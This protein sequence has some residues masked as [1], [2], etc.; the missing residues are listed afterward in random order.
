[1][2]R[3]LYLKTM[4]AGGAMAFAKAAEMGNP[5]ELHV[6]LSIDPAREQE[7]LHNFKTLFLP[8]GKKATWVR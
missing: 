5:I 8:G 4:L 6:D 7:M 3:R 2:K 1:M